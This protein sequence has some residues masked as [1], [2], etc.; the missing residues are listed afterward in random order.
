VGK[1]AMTGYL[2]VFGTDGRGMLWTNVQTGQTSWSGWSRIPAPPLQGHLAIARDLEGDFHLFGVDFG[3]TV[4]TNAQIAPGGGWQTRWQRLSS[5]RRRMPIL[6]GFVC[7]INSNGDLQLFGAGADGH[8]YTLAQTNGAWGSQWMALGG[9]RIGPDLAVATTADGRLQIF[10]NSE[11]W[12]PEIWS[13]WQT[14][15]GGAWSGWE[16]FGG[17]GDRLY[18]SQKQAGR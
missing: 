4:W 12:A 14:N 18:S 15:P 11:N 6:P 13:N 9:N 3:G 7:G 2:Q 16:D 5:L 10:G 17:S 8:V 1:N